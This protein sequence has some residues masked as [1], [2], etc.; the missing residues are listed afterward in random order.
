MVICYKYRKDS[1][2]ILLCLEPKN[3]SNIK[4]IDEIKEDIF[5]ELG[6]EEP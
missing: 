1:H 2:F 3:T 5:K 4:E 6:K